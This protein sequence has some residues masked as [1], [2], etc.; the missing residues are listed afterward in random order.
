MS[1]TIYIDCNRLNAIDKD[2][3]NKAEWIYRN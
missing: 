1:K 3:D 2:S